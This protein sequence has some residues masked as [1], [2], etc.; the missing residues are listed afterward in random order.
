M[1]RLFIVACVLLVLAPAPAP[2]A[3]QSAASIAEAVQSVTADDILNR[4]K[5]DISNQQ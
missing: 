2:V 3:A 5:L 4:K 1:M